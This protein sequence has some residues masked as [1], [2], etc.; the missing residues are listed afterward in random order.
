MIDFHNHVLPNVDDGSK[1]MEMTLNMLRTASEQG[2]KKKKNT[3]HLQHP[4]MEGKNT[5]F[6]Y[7]SSLRD[8]LLQEMKKEKI[9]IDIH[10]GA[11]VFYN[12]N[13]LDIL[14]VGPVYLAML[15]I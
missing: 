13:L 9:S 10:L 8:E 11:E 6:D 5:N 7:I 4:K 2:I 14:D 12:F 15:L 3:T 1:N